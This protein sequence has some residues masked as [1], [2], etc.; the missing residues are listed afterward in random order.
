MILIFSSVVAFRKIKL[1]N[2]PNCAFMFVI[3]PKAGVK[4]G[5][6]GCLAA[7][8]DDGDDDCGEDRT[9]CQLSQVCNV[10]RERSR[11]GGVKGREV[12]EGTGAL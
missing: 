7:C 5:G 12:E 9:L 11:R 10:K 4:G 2:R 1:C 3:G 8:D 6:R